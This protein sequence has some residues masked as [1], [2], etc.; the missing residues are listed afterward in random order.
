MAEPLYPIAL[1]LEGRLV[2]VVGSGPVAESKT[3]SLL[4]AGARVR[5][6]AP[7]AGFTW[8]H[9][10]LEIRKRRF[11]CDDLDDCWLVVSAATPSVNHDVAAEAHARR[12]FAIAVDDPSNGSAYGMAVLRRGGRQ[13]RGVLTIG[14]STDGE[15]P[16]L[17]GLVREALDALLPGEVG[18]WLGLARR[19]R[20]EWRR[21]GV[22]MARRRP[23]LLAAL[24]ELYQERPRLDRGGAA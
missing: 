14:I 5:L 20:G 21:D 13:G 17:A 16:A 9:M 8:I 3:K 6:V 15:A 2:L 22:P 10:R 1:K 7:D 19:L 11:R 12:V 24:N 18:A 4:E 23:L